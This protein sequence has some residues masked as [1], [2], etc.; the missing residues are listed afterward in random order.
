MTFFNDLNFDCVKESIWRVT[1]K[2]DSKGKQKLALCKLLFNIGIC[3]A[4][5]DFNA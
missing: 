4:T 1:V 3:A 2:F 5:M